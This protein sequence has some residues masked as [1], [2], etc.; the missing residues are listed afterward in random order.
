MFTYALN[1]NHFQKCIYVPQNYYFE[2]VI[3]ISFMELVEM[4]KNNRHE[5]SFL[6]AKH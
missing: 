6:P 5:S 1:L 3:H 2:Y 4:L